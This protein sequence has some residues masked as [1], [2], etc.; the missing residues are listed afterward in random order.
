MRWVICLIG[1][2]VCFLNYQCSSDISSEESSKSGEALAKVYCASCHQ[3]PEP[4]LLDKASWNNA[5]LPRMGYML[6]I[7]DDKLT[8]D[9]LIEKGPGGKLVEAAN[10]FPEQPTIALE[11]W[12][13]NQS[14][15]F[16][17]CSC[18]AFRIS[19]KEYQNWLGTF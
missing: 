2:A 10:I 6:G 4:Q 3:F 1:L 5:V 15:L 16:R 7:Y 8:K 11:T 14:V 13:K 17:E 12:E 19:R 18:K 9:S